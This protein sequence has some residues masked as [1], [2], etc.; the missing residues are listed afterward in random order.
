MSLG[1]RRTKSGRIDVKTK[2]Y[3]KTHERFAAMFN[4]LIYD[5]KPVIKPENLAPLDST[6]AAIIDSNG[7]EIPVQKVRD[8]FNALEILE[9]DHAVYVLLGEEFQSEVHY[10]G[11]VK[12][13]VY[14]GVSFVDQIKQFKRKYRGKKDDAEIAF[15]P[16]G[17][18]IK[19]THAEFLSG[20][21]KGD[22]LKPVITLMVYLG[23]GEWDGPRSLHDMLYFPDERLKAFVPDYKLNLIVPRELTDGDFAKFGPDLGFLLKVLNHGEKGIAEMLAE[24]QYRSVDGETALI[25]NDIAK[26]GLEIVINEGGKANMC[27][28]M[29]EHDQKTKVQAGVELARRL[30]GDNKPEIVRVVSDQYKVTPEYVRSVM[31][32]NSSVSATARS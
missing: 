5:G 13:M 24:P 4:F 23:T 21:R 26:L 30:L 6:E 31:S 25:A 10:A 14:D 11:P 7:V 17:V 28:A 29:K 18:K 15:E 16:D 22:K 1:R 27:K 3:M 20:L 9:D 8:A 2:E 19:L 12:D 32:S